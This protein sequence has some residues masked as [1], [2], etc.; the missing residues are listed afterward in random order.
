[1]N[2][3]EALRNAQWYAIH[4]KVSP[5]TPEDLE[6]IAELKLEAA[7]ESGAVR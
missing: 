7:F 4:R 2:A 1:M 5:L 3:V 6:Y